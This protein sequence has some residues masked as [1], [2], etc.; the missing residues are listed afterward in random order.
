M[1]ELRRSDL[2]LKH[3]VIRAPRGLVRVRDK[4]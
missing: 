2:D 1:I 4:V 3:G